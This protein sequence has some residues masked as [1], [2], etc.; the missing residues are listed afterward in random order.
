MGGTVW[1]AFSPD[2]S[3]SVSAYWPGTSIA[4]YTGSAL[5]QLSEVGALCSNSPLTFRAEAGTTYYFQAR[6]VSDYAN[7][8]FRLELPPPP[9]AYFS[10]YPPDPLALEEI[11]FY[12]DCS[13]PAGVGIESCAWDLGDGT[14]ATGYWIQHRYEADGDYVVRLT[15]TTLDGRQAS[16]FQTVPVRTHDVAIARFAAP[17]AAKAGQTRTINVGISS[18][19]YPN[20]V[21]VYLYKSLP[22]GFE[23]VGTLRQEVLVHRAG[24]TTD[25]RFS[26]T[27]TE[28]DASAGKVTFRATA[29]IVDA[30]DA[31]PAD[32]EAISSPTKVRR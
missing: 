3:V 30:R 24:R 17:K 23:Q 8:G 31:W 11:Q 25:F 2:E 26:Y 15:V 21:D 4:A 32:N 29:D 12:G 18:K 13:D 19:L 28:D 7:L 14:S 6:D 22:W 1:Y 10:F 16:A 9:S 20:E 27:F 5:D